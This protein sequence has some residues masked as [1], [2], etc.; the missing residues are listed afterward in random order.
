VKKLILVLAIIFLF[1]IISFAADITLQ[2]DTST[3]ASGYK[4]YKSE[5]MGATWDIGID[6]GN[7]TTYVYPNV[8]EDKM[9]LFRASSYNSSG[10]S[11]RFEAGVW[12]DKRKLPPT[13]PSGTGIL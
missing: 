10:E 5:D 3:G 2:W 6:V 4:I 9:V 8:A 7:V 13:K 12:Y 11:I 1:P